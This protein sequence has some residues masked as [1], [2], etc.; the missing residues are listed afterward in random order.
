LIPVFA[1]L[2][3]GTLLGQSLLH[4]ASLA[5]LQVEGVALHI[6]NDV[7]GHNL[8]LEAS[9][10]VFQRFAFLQSNFC[11]LVTLKASQMNLFRAYSLLC[12]A[13]SNLMPEHSGQKRRARSFRITIVVFV[14]VIFF[15][16]VVF[17]FVFFLIRF[18]PN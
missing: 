9:E 16:A 1:N 8:A 11:H 18:L 14:I 4:S 15:F 13:Q 3:S 12:H 7:F 10:C 2:L 5:R 17:L 6:L